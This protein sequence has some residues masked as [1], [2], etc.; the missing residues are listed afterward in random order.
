MHYTYDP[1]AD[2]LYIYL[3]EDAPV[4]KTFQFDGQRNVDVDAQGDAVGIEVLSPGSS[5]P[6]EDLITRFNLS[7]FKDFLESVST[8]PFKPVT[9]TIGVIDRIR[10]KSEVDEEEAID[11]ASRAVHE[12]RSGED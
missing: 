3:R 6:I 9:P 12:I 8:T 2:A 7:G 1:Q 10:S 4:S 11:A 5:F